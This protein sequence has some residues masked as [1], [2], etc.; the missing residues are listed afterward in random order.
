MAERGSPE[1]RQ[2]LSASVKARFAQRAAAGIKHPR[3]GVKPTKRSAAQ[4]AEHAAKQALAL[5][6][7]EE[8]LKLKAERQALK[9]APEPHKL[10]A[11]RVR[12]LEEVANQAA[13]HAKSKAERLALKE[14]RE[15]IER[16]KVAK[17]SAANVREVF[18]EMML[19]GKMLLD[20]KLD[21]RVAKPL[22]GR[23]EALNRSFEAFIR[24][25]EYTVT[26]R[27]LPSDRVTKTTVRFN[28]FGLTGWWGSGEEQSKQVKK[29]LARRRLAKG[30]EAP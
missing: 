6:K 20:R 27:A 29:G 2:R 11:K 3:A 1:W 19:T 12:S 21:R 18:E 23:H 15:R 25:T 22:A 26:R 9:A 8:A 17:T 13:S 16:P 30:A 4:R 24:E 10:K 14:E 7:R 28:R 5:A